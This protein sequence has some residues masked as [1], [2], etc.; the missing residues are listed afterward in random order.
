VRELNTLEN[1]IIVFSSDNGAIYESLHESDMYP[2]RQEACPRLGS[3]KPYRG[4]KAQLY[5]GGI[6]TPTAVQWCGRLAPGVIDDPVHVVDWM[7]TFARLADAPPPGEA[8]WD[9]VDISDLLL[10]RTPPA[11]ERT[12][13]WNF[14]GGAEYAVR[15][16]DWKLIRRNHDHGPRTELFDIAADPYEE[17]ECSAQEPDVVAALE[18]A[19]AGQIELDNASVRPGVTGP[20]V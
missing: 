16:G 9:G 7:P 11:V 12:L 5:E 18:R 6:R 14:R 8:R 17:N 10:E 4:Q 20:H 13:F 1:T 19:M 2:G 3:N 15:R